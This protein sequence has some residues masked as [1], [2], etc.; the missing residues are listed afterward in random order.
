MIKLVKVSFLIC[1]F[2]FTTSLV[3]AGKGKSPVV[4]KVNTPKEKNADRNSDGLVTKQEI[5][6]DKKKH[7]DIVNKEWEK[8][9]DLNNDGTVDDKELALWKDK[10]PLPPNLK[11]KQMDLNNDGTVDDK[12]KML[13]KRKHQ[14]TGDSQ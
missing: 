3:F 8:K 7:D 6:T 12:E 1:L 10:H 9:A 5:R 14:G 11:E 13:W 4:S 2:I